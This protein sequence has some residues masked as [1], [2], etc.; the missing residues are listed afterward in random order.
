[1]MK[2]QSG[3]LKKLSLKLQL[4]LRSRTFF[5][6]QNCAQ[7]GSPAIY[8]IIHLPFDK[9]LGVRFMLFLAMIEEVS[10]LWNNRGQLRV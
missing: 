1:M 4:F 9:C 10:N 6:K 5:L 3:S 8:K 7:R 2:T